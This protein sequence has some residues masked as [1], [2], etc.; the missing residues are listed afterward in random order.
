VILVIQAF[1]PW[2]GWGCL[3]CRG[4]VF[5]DAAAPP[6]V[7]EA[8]IRRSASTGGGAKNS[9]ALQSCIVVSCEC[10]TSTISEMQQAGVEVVVIAG[11]ELGKGCIGV[12]T[13]E[14]GEWSYGLQK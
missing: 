13:E 9:V 11:F 5:R 14:R 1:R 7:S 2:K 4:M 10:N 6:V 12:P 3:T 8:L